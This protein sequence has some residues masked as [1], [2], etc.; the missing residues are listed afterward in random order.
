MTNF[1]QK[2]SEMKDPQIQKILHRLCCLFACTNFIDNNFGNIF[3]RDQYRLINEAVST[4]L[5][6]IR[7]DCVSLV[8]VF[9][10]PDSVLKSTIGRYDGNVYEA[11][12]DAAQKSTLNLTDPFDGY[13][14]YLKPHLNKD[15]LKH[16]N[17]PI[18]TYGKL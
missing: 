5:L 2:V 4:L 7:P 12:F 6:E 17:K 11:L 18:S 14:Q 15:L 10:M 16:G 13:D 1:A 3:E 9:D 8:D